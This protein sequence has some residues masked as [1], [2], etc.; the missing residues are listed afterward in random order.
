[1]SK[2]DANKKP[3]YGI[4]TKKQVIQEYYNS[5]ASMK[6]LSEIHGILGSNT[7][8]E[9]LK[10]YGDLRPKNLPK[11]PTMNKPHASEQDKQKRLRKYKS[12]EQPYLSQL[13]IDLEQAQTR[14]R[15]YV[16]AVDV[17]NELAQELTG[18]DLLKKTGLELSKRS[19]KQE[20]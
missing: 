1:M 20:S 18:I 15:F 17:I 14:L 3:F 10:K 9:W 19:K 2:K 7:L 16:L 11:S 5:S 4:R 12:T 13:E 8:S 6:E